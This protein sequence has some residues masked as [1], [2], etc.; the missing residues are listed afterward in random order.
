MRP[1]AWQPVFFSFLMK[2]TLNKPER[3]T[4]NFTASG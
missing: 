3:R 1:L 4:L 2:D